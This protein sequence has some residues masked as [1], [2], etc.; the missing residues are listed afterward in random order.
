MKNN[1]YVISFDGPFHRFSSIGKTSLYEFSDFIGKMIK[2]NDCRKLISH[3]FVRVATIYALFRNKDIE[4][5]KYVLLIT[6]D[7]FK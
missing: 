5:D 3:S 7:K 2:E 4:I 1:Y 6:P